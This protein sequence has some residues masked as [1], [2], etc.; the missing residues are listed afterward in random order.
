MAVDLAAPVFDGL[1]DHVDH[2]LHFA[3]DIV[4]DDFDHAITVNA[5]GTALLMHRF[6]SARSILVVSSTVVY[7]LHPDPAHHF[8]E[9]DP[10]G[11]SKPLFGRTYPVSKIAQEA[12][13][14]AMCR[15]VEVPTTIARMNLSYG[16]NGG[17]PAYQLDALRRGDPVTVAAEDTHHNPFHQDDI[18]ASIPALLDAAS[19]PATIVNWA[20]PETVSMRTYCRYLGELVGVE[21]VF[22]EID[23]FMRGRG[24]DTTKQVELVGPPSIGWRE[25]MRRLV[26]ERA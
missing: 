1:P 11:D 26:A 9:T 6:R 14:R 17:L 24:V 15:A 23:G 7:D 12:A 5:E 4:G 20:G 22:E 25:G 18:V 8:A 10:L 21:P 2:V 16:A 3:A 19:V 13:A